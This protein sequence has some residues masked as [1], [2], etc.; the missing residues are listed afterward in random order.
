[1][2][3]AFKASAAPFHAWTPDVYQGAPAPVVAF[4]SVGTKVAA[5]AVFLRLFAGTFGAPSVLARWTILLGAVAGL[6]MLVGALGAL[7]Q[8]DLKRMLAYSSVAQAGYLLLGG[9]GRAT[10]PGWLVVSSAL[11]RTRP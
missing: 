4:M 7:R 9:G 1:M 6:S 10:G 11:R 5:I 8:P 2:G 3:L